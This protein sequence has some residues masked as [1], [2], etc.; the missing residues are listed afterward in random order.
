MWHTWVERR[1]TYRA[2][3]GKQDGEY[4]E[5]LGIDDQDGKVW[6]GFM[7]VRVATSSMPF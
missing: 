5:D 3:K 7:W 6:T 1:N 2:S 4:L